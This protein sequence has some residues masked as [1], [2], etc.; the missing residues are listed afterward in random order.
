MSNDHTIDRR[1]LVVVGTLVTMMVMGVVP[2][3]RLPRVDSADGPVAGV[4]YVVT[5]GD[6]FLAGEGSR[7][8][9]NGP[10]SNAVV[11][12][13]VD[14]TILNTWANVDTGA[15]YDPVA[16]P[17]A[18]AP[19]HRT[20]NAE[21]HIDTN[22]AGVARDA[23]VRTK[24]LAC[25]G[26]STGSVWYNN[27]FYPGVDFTGSAGDPYQGQAFQLQEFAKKNN[28]KLV[29]LSIGGNDLDLF[30]ILH[31]C[32][33]A[34]VL[35]VVSSM[36]S[37]CSDDATLRA[38]VGSTKM[39][40]VQRK[41]AT[42]IDNIQRAMANAG[43]SNGS[44][45]LL[46]QTYPIAFP[47]S[48]R[49][50]YPEYDTVFWQPRKQAC[51]LFNRDV[52][53]AVN[54]V[55]PQ[56]N[57]AAR[58]AAA[59]ENIGANNI[60]VL[61][62][63][64]ALDGHRVCEKGVDSTWKQWNTIGPGVEWVLGLE[65]GLIGSVLGPPG[66]AERIHPT[67]WGTWALRNC[68]RQAWNA[69]Q[70]QAGTCTPMSSDAVNALGEPL[71]RFNGAGPVQPPTTTPTSASGPVIYQIPTCTNLAPGGGT[72]AITTV[73]NPSGSIATQPGSPR[74]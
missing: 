67:A 49:M 45:S 17:P 37:Y 44:W 54:T 65:V 71:M 47:S 72:C 33:K 18:H 2:L 63:E 55:L 51:P 16:L 48:D 32:I 53:W 58:R 25:S 14:P 9:T 46:V 11:P 15:R 60:G 64:H 59:S 20:R 69:G 61:D 70:V 23:T 13:G 56:L 19:C 24:N 74:P 1:R 73:P 5:V 6:S 62:L 40:E 30:A 29:V 21:A 31:P 4:P 57:T 34:Y 52:N 7:W 66:V 26:S 38:K 12:Y 36:A 28:V 50:R 39:A 68:L 3:Q 41:I 27:K 35:A 22:I 8:A 42:A 43:Y 10:P